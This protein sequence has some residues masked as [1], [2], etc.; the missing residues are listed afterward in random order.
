MGWN[1][2]FEIPTVIIAFVFSGFFVISFF[3]SCAPILHCC[4]RYRCHFL[5]RRTWFVLPLP[6]WLP[7]KTPGIMVLAGATS[8]KRYLV[9]SV[10]SRIFFRT[11]LTCSKASASL[12]RKLNPVCIQIHK[13]IFPYIKKSLLSGKSKR[14][15]S[16]R[17]LGPKRQLGKKGPFR[18]NFCS[19][20]EAVRC[21]GIGPHRPRKGP[22]IIIDKPWKGPN[23][24]RKARFSRAE[25]P[26]IL[27]EILGL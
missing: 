11:H 18:D 2:S 20:S 13:F 25:F 10:A 19:F 8:C 1:L 6:F 22:P 3:Q 14:G 4:Y 24:P 26:P 12:R 15:L 21:G 5:F 17:G 9:V 27:S 16:K 23:R 7:R